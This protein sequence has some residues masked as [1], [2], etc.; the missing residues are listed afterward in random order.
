[1]L[2]AQNATNTYIF[3]YLGFTFL[4]LIL[5]L[6]NGCGR[7]VMKTFVVT[8]GNNPHFS[9]E[10]PSNYK[11]NYTPSNSASMLVEVIRYLPHSPYMNPFIRIEILP[12]DS[13]GSDDPELILASDIASNSKKIGF[14]IVEN[15]SIII[16]GVRAK[17]YVYNYQSVTEGKYDTVTG[18]DV[19][20][21][22]DDFTW[23]IWINY[24][25]LYAD[26]VE[27]DIDHFEKTFKLLP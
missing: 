20:F 23:K 10:Y 25:S 3:K 16:D 26:K 1:M 4:A 15:G 27:P 24:D 7:V 8:D 21:N 22:H 11:Y 13:F 2:N 17:Y 14:K 6:V 5:F 9:F 18:K 12:L 19:V